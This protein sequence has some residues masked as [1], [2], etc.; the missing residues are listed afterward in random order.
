MA[1]ALRSGDT[2]AADGRGWR[3]AGRAYMTVGYVF[4][5]LPIVTMIVFSFQKG[6]FASL[7]ARAGACNGTASCLPTAL[8]SRPLA[9]A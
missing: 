9:I 7:P 1:A 2:L 5:M 3:L 6:Q 8:C 4:L